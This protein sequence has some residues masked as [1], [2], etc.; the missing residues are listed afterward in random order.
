MKDRRGQKM[1]STN[2]I[3]P[4]IK[5][6]GPFDKK[7]GYNVLTQSMIQKFFEYLRGVGAD[8]FFICFYPLPADSNQ[9]VAELMR[10]MITTA[11]STDTKDDGK[12]LVAQKELRSK[13]DAAAKRAE[14][15]VGNSNSRVYHESYADGDSIAF[16]ACNNGVIGSGWHDSAVA[17]NKGMLM[18]D[19]LLYALGMI[20]AGVDTKLWEATYR[21]LPYDSGLNTKDA[22]NIIVEAVSKLK[23]HQNN[24][25]S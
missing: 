16:V 2:N 1:N 25:F 12:L 19:F 23:V 22:D 14:E 18:A 13:L 21:Y 15:Y 17:A 9:N 20:N 3:I 7:N 6:A 11:S 10:G 4:F 8:V 24:R 5:K